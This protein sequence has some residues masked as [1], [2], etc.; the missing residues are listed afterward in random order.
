MGMPPQKVFND[1]R[2]EGEGC[3]STW[4][5]KTGFESWNDLLQKSGFGE[6]V[7][8]DNNHHCEL[9]VST[10]ESDL[11]VEAYDRMEEILKKILA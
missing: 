6:A 4:V 2:A 10:S 11:S 8:R 5:R 3:A 9:I 7:R 1:E